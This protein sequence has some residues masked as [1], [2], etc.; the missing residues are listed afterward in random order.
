MNWKGVPCKVFNAGQ[1]RRQLLGATATSG[2][3]FFDPQNPKGAE[4][5]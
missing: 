2:A 3:E 5:R 1:Y 4:L